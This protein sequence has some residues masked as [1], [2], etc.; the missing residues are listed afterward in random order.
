MVPDSQAFYGCP[1]TTFIASPLPLHSLCF[2]HP[3]S[4]PL[5]LHYYATPRSRTSQRRKKEQT[6][7]AVSRQWTVRA[8]Q[9][10]TQSISRSRRTTKS[11]KKNARFSCSVSCY[12][13]LSLVVAF[14]FG[15]VAFIKGL[16]TE[17]RPTKSHLQPPPRPRIRVTPTRANSFA[18]FRFR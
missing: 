14:V 3:S 8:R 12:F 2:L 9:S 7:V 10:Q 1:T 13:S 17:R 6:W 11:T 18:F 15:G 16:R 5:P 4:R